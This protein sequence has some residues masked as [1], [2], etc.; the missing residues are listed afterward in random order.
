MKGSYL[1]VLVFGLFVIACGQS[2]HQD[3]VPHPYADRFSTDDGD[4]TLEYLGYFGEQTPGPLMGTK[5]L[6]VGTLQNSSQSHLYWGEEE[7]P[8]PEHVFTRVAFLSAK[9]GDTK[10]LVYRASDQDDEGNFRYWVQ[11][12]RREP[13]KF[14][15]IVGKVQFSP[16]DHERFGKGER[17]RP[18][19]DEV[20]GSRPLYVGLVREPFG[21]E[22]MWGEESL[23]FYKNQPTQPLYASVDGHD[24]PQPTFFVKKAEGVYVYVVGRTEYAVNIPAPASLD[25]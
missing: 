3:P 15:F 4:F 18:C 14:A 20:L 13:K 22:V 10:E 19:F 8:C 5:P 12:G 16:K 7:Y 6:V 24:E 23:G 21:F 1:F 9:Y 11:W 25:Q 17:C 2:R